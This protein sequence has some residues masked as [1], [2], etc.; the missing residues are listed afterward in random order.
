MPL[1]RISAVSMA[2][3]SM[4][5]TILS[6]ENAELTNRSRSASV[7]RRPASVRPVHPR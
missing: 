1:A 7:W 4:L 5:V 6:A 2:R 3:G